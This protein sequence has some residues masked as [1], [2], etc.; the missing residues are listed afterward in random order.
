MMDDREM[1]QY[2]DKDVFAEKDSSI[3]TLTPRSAFFEEYHP[4]LYTRYLEQLAS[5]PDRPNSLTFKYVH[6]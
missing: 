3:S 4:G 1:W 5:L 2:V 6:Q